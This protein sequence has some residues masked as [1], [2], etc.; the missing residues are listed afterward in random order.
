MTDKHEKNSIEKYLS[1]N[2]KLSNK[3]LWIN[4]INLHKC[5]RLKIYLVVVDPNKILHFNHE[6]INHFT[7][8]DSPFPG[9]AA[10]SCWSLALTTT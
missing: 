1:N 3:F 5:I 10:H 9:T 8:T 2:V 4:G 6:A 7:V